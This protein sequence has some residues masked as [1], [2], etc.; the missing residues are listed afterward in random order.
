[1]TD[2]PYR[3]L[4]HG[5]G[6]SAAVS[7]I[8]DDKRISARAHEPLAAA[9]LA[10]GIRV[11]RTISH[12]HTARGVF[13]GIGVC[14]DCVMQVNGVPGIRACVTPVQDGMR[15][16]TQQNTGAWQFVLSE[17]GST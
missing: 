4:A 9:L 6:E 1:M 11:C 10:H 2:E 15:V 16:E 12:D 3:I 13:C 14:G 8:V 7:L 17:T 5:V